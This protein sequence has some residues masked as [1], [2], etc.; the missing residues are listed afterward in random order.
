M[1]SSSRIFSFGLGRSPSRSLVKGLARATNGHFVF[2]PPDTNVDVY[3]GEQLEKAL[4]S[5]ITN[6][7]VKWN[8]G[9]NVMNVP[10][11]TP[12]V[13]VNDRLIVYALVN[14]NN[15]SISFDHNS[16][17]ELF[18]DK[19]RLG[20]A[21]VNR[22][23]HV[24]D[25]GTIARLAAK[26]LILELQHSN[27][28]SLNEK[29]GSQ[30]VRFIKQMH[31]ETQKLL[32]DD[33]E[34]RKKRIIEL[35]L[36]YNILSP[37]TAFVGIEKRVNGN[38]DDMILRKVSIQISADNKHLYNFLRT[39]PSFA[40]SRTYCNSLSKDCDN[41]RHRLVPN[42]S[43]KKVDCWISSDWRTGAHSAYM[44]CSYDLCSDQAEGRMLMTEKKEEVFPTNDQ[45]IIR[46][47]ISKQTFDG[48]WDL[49]SKNIEQLT[50]KP[51]S[52]FPKSINTQF[53]A[54][55]IVITVFE[56]RFASF[57]SMWHGIVQKARKRLLDLFANDG[58]K[59]DKL[60]KDIRKNL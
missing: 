16:N 34:E 14:D 40:S 2:I 15:Q 26:A 57:S 4:Q 13:Y 54:T 17:V 7:L 60:L 39:Q 33:K 21:K 22:I 50:G 3:V 53:I 37:Y 41:M 27:L 42:F 30:Q 47:L 45:D 29:S 59:L 11:I 25:N 38:N 43:K 28:S 23:P 55:A 1:S 12:P 58:K 10:T 8:L 20:E 46:Y 35:S 32:N 5:S 56:T 18:N 44:N 24:S 48:L 6:V 19:H 31:D 49:D 36:K 51:L 9:T 52:K